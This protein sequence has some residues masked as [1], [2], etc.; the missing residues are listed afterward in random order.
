MSRPEEVEKYVRCYELEH[1]RMGVI[2]KEDAIRA[3][4]PLIEAG[5]SYLDIGCGR[6]E[7]LDLAD[8]WGASKT[9][10]IETVPALCTKVNVWLGSGY[11][12]PFEDNSFDVV[13]LFDVI[14][15]IPRE[16]ELLV[17]NEMKR[18]ANKA[19][20]LTANNHQSQLPDGTEL[21]INIREYNDWDKLLKEVYSGWDITW[22][23]NP[24]KRNNSETWVIKR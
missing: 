8:E 9:Q 18:V 14:E 12:L 10:G 1:Y 6:G 16:D 4:Q 13:S 5:S 22:M 3:L 2:R 15:H 7:M 11:D 23:D 20:V 19:V 21:H 17:L 24:K